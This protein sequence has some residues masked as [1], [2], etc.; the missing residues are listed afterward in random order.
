MFL[1]VSIMLQWI[2]R[3]VPNA[4]DADQAKSDSLQETN[5]TVVLAA[6]KV[7]NTKRSINFGFNSTFQLTNEVSHFIRQTGNQLYFRIIL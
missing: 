3:T 5:D 7:N 4:Y 6:G 2:I 1:P